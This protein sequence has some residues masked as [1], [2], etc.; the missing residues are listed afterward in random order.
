MP[1]PQNPAPHEADAPEADASDTHSP[2][3]D[4][5]DTHSPETDAPA[6][7]PAATRPMTTAEQ[8][9]LRRKLQDKF[10]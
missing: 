7:G 8:E 5:P 4:A 1:P 10:H 2:E 3:A 6:R 9:A